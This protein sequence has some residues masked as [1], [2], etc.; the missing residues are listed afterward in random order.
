MLTR[1][2]IKRLAGYSYARGVE[3]F[4][5]GK[6]GSFYMEGS[7]EYDRIRA[8]VKGSGRHRYAVEIT[9]NTE[10]DE[11]E[12]CGCECPAFYS[13]DGLCKHCVESFWNI[14]P[15]CTGGKRFRRIGTG[16]KNR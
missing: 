9:V 11:I 10:T 8:L 6:V 5:Q 16:G 3:I 15:Y 14:C 1:S 7:E 2:G 4:N 13:Y 12:D